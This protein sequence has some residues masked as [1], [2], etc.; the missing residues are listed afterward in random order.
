[1]R[2]SFLSGFL[3]EN[4]FEKHRTRFIACFLR[5]QAA[6]EGLAQERLIRRLGAGKLLF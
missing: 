5:D 4:V 3:G 2:F 6:S 1:L